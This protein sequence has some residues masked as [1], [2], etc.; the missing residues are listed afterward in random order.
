MRLLKEAAGVLGALV[1]VAVI[2]AFIAPKRTHA[3]VAAL[4]QVTN[5]SANPV[6]VTATDNPA[7]FPFGGGLCAAAVEGPC[8]STPNFFTV[9]EK[10]STG[11][12]VK[13]LV[14]EEASALCGIGGTPVNAQLDIPFPA[15]NVSNGSPVVKLEFSITP[16]DPPYSIIP[17]TA[18]P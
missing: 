9:P 6:P 3:L 4:V 2:V 11:V 15:D 16:I 7:N 14:I 1:V 12:T 13:R 17:S 10:T 8:G 18:I 5:T